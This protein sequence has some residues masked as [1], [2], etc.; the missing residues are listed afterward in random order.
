MA[1]T[2]ATQATTAEVKYKDGCM[3]F[4]ILY[5]DHTVRV[6]K[7][8]SGEIFV[9]NVRGVEATIRIGADRDG[10]SV[11][12]HDGTFTPWAINGLPAFLVRGKK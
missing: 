9:E 6:F 3:S 7:N 8:P 10:L 2:D 4:P 5:E 12:A 11:T 1:R